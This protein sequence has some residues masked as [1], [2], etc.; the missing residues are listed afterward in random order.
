MT[1]TLIAVEGLDGAGKS[2]QVALLAAALGA[3]EVVS[4]PRY[5]TFFG[6][7]IRW[8]LDGAGEVSAQTVDPRS[9]ALWYALDRAQWARDRKPV[10]DNGIVLL[11]RY[12]LSNAVYQSARADADLFDWVL[13]L[14]FEELGLPRP[15]VTVILDVPP[16]LSRNRVARRGDA[17][18][19]VYERAGELLARVRDGY[20]AAAFRLPDVVVVGADGSPDA[21]HAAVLMALAPYLD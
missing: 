19:D 13:R 2:T 9:M 7:Q 1:Q 18:G 5:D 10:P 20:L 3:G 4:F 11:N 15:D 8:L 6:R 17:D 16:E 21:V 12:T 14:E